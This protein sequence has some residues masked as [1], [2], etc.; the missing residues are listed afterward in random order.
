MSV[1]TEAI[2][3]EIERQYDELKKLTGD[4]LS[5]LGLDVDLFY[6]GV[7]VGLWL[8][9]GRV[10]DAEREAEVARSAFDRAD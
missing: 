1:A 2:R 9:E 10:R 8:A 7:R 3:T 6:Q 5:D 4:E